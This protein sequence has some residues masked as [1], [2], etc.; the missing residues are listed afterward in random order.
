MGTRPIG[1]TSVSIREPPS[2]SWQ[3][4]QREWS[5][6]T[7]VAVTPAASWTWA[8]RVQSWRNVAGRPLELDFTTVPRSVVV[9]GFCSERVG[10]G[11]GGVEA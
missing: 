4:A 11:G 7:N 1:T 5:G 10:D 3:L 9:S 8:S 2:A 6:L